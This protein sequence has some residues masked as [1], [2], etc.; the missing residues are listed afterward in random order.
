MHRNFLLDQITDTYFNDH[1]GNGL[2]PDSN[3]I[4]IQ[5][6]YMCCAKNGA[7]DYN[8]T[9]GKIPASCC[10]ES[11]G[12][13]DIYKANSKGCYQIMQEMFRYTEKERVVFTFLGRVSVFV[14]AFFIHKNIFNE[15][16]D[17]NECIRQ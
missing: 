16:R 3:F 14:V 7:I 10:G 9:R 6:K 5:I 11:E 12:F 2:K 1:L 15:L 13:C 17:K 8:T 4:E